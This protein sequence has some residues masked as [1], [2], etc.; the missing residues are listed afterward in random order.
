M[1]TRVAETCRWSLTYS[2][3]QLLTDL[4]VYLLTYSFNYLATYLL[5]HSITS[6]LTHSLTH[7]LT[8]SLTHLLTYLVTYLLNYLLACLLTYLLTYSV[9]Q[10]STWEANRFSASQVIPRTLWNPKVHYC[11]H[12]WLYVIKLYTHTHTHIRVWICWFFKKSYTACARDMEHTSTERV[13]QID[14]VELTHIPYNV[15]F[16]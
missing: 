2:L 6:S 5:T 7:P 16:P 8:H 1:T 13:Y 4:L 15:C 12:K 10:S 3:I 14:A 11:I 9:K